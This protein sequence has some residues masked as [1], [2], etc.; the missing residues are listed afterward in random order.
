MS[1]SASQ[2]LAREALVS[3]RE[4]TYFNCTVSDM[5]APGYRPEGKC[6]HCKEVVHVIEKSAYDQLLSEH[7]GLSAQL[8]AMSMERDQLTKEL[9]LAKD[10]ILMHSEA[11]NE[12]EKELRNIEA[13]SLFRE[14]VEL[15]RELAEAKAKLL[16]MTDSRDIWA[17]D[18]DKAERQLTEARAEIEAMKGT[19]KRLERL[20]FDEKVEI[21]SRD[22]L[23]ER[24]SGAL[25]EAC[26]GFVDQSDVLKEIASWRNQK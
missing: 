19:A 5:M 23:I 22:A 10:R 13:G 18:C 20:L 1:D 9:D 25:I 16:S 15:R 11:V 14:V 7:E 21:Q 3:P 24:L 8:M 6:H 12:L 4:W 2:G 26:D 17:E